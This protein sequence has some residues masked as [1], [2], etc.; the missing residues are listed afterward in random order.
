[1]ALKFVHLHTGVYSWPSRLSLSSAIFTD[2]G[3]IFRYGVVFPETK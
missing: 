3:T 2:E 1:M